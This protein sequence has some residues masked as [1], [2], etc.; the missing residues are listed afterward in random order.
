MPVS[1]SPRRH[2]GCA[3]HPRLANAVTHGARPPAPRGC[4]CASHTGTRPPGLSGAPGC[5]CSAPGLDL[6]VRALDCGMLGWAGIRAPGSKDSGRRWAQGQLLDTCGVTAEHHELC[7]PAS[8]SL[9][10]GWRH[11]GQS[12]APLIHTPT[13]GPTAV[14]CKGPP[15]QYA[16]SLEW[17]P[18]PGF[19]LHCPRES[20]AC[21]PCFRCRL[22]VCGDRETEGLGL[23]GILDPRAPCALRKRFG[24]AWGNPV[25]G[26]WGSLELTVLAGPSPWCPALESRGRG[27]S[28][29]ISNNPRP[30]GGYHGRNSCLTPSSPG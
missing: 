7:S 14:L 25:S 11:C 2:A 30:L 21:A 24:W 10:M 9:W 28:G 8:S 22:R 20:W 16:C 18:L 12:G 19:F 27:A 3:R 26:S 4:P 17:G 6:R 5:L 29:S 15:F 1:T 23:R 13:S